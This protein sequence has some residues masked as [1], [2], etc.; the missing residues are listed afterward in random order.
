MR[1]RPLA[2]GLFTVVALGPAAVHAG[3]FEASLRLGQAFPFYEQTFRY[4]AGAL[5][6]S[7]AGLRVDQSGVFSL[8]GS[9]GLA[10]GASLAYAFNDHAGVELR[11]DTADVRVRTEGA[12]YRVRADLPPPL[13]DLDTE[14][15]LAHGTVDLERLRPLSLNLLARTGGARRQAFVSAGAS[16]LPGFRLEVRQDIG[17]TLPRLFS[18][19]GTLDL[20][21]VTLAAEALPEEEGEGR[22]GLNG[23]AG[24]ALAVGSRA[25]ITVEGR[26]FHFQRQTLGWARPRGTGVLPALE[27]AIVGQVTEA[28]A[29]VKFSPRFFHAAAGVALRF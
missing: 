1:S 9:G 29:P 19:R 13:P 7:I 15:D 4:D 21:Q 5:L 11:L 6:P 28:L 27:E 10:L 22:L 14:V 17:L 25:W 23:G 3:G 8:N 2:W 18:G 20:A 24:L 16:Y 26:Y 12:R